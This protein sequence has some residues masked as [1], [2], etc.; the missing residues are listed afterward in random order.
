MITAHLVMNFLMKKRRFAINLKIFSMPYAVWL[1][2]FSV[3]PMVFVLYYSITNPENNFTL[4]NFFEIK[5]YSRTFVR[6]IV[7]SSIS[8]LISFLLGYPAA[9]AISKLSKKLQKIVIAGVILQM[10]I[11]FLLTI[12]SLMTIMESNG[13]INK[14]FNIFGI[15]C[16]IINT[17][18]AVIIGMVY[19]S[20]PYMI[21]PIYSSLSKLD[22]KI[23]EAAQDLGAG[24][25]KIFTKII[26]PLST[27]GVL[28]G[29]LM[30]FAPNMSSFIISKM[31]GGSENVL[32]GEVIELKFLG[33]Q[34]NPWSGSAIAIILMFFIIICTSV[35]G[36]LIYYKSEK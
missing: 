18:I 4:E 29:F 36:Y 26:F 30:V 13:I 27:P 35:V 8:T 2:L 5:N 12:Y 16:P 6:S 11:S 9:Y 32:I 19:S 28:S 34:Y 33:G 31:L 22:V 1:F 25:L 24:K 10:W 17:K 14:F 20:L 7:F 23:I 3:L 21:L 15:D